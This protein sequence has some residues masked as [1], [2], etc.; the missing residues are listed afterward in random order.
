M[1]THYSMLNELNCV[2]KNRY[3]IPLQQFPRITTLIKSSDTDVKTKAAVFETMDI[4]KFV[5]NPNN[6]PYW[7]T[8]KAVQ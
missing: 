1:W 7:I 3:G 4:I 6:S 2:V 8:R 5:N